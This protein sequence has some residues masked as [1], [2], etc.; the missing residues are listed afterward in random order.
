MLLHHFDSSCSCSCRFIKACT[1]RVATTSADRKKVIRF[2]LL[3]WGRR[4]GCRLLMMASTSSSCCCCCFLWWTHSYL[5]HP[6][7]PQPRITT[8]HSSGHLQ[9]SQQNHTKQHIV[10]LE[11][12]PKFLQQP[13]FASYSRETFETRPFEQLLSIQSTAT[14]TKKKKEEEGAWRS[15]ALRDGGGERG[16]SFELRT[17]CFIPPPP[18]QRFCLLHSHLLTSP[19]LY[20]YLCQEQRLQLSLYTLQQQKQKLH[21]L[22]YTSATTT[23]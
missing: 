3:V 20:L 17:Q 1:V 6:E 21:L 13:S 15:K 7:A 8:W 5:C 14:T 4:R 2:D 16:T 18:S 11:L 23:I 19:D 10:I 12:L 22:S 9:I